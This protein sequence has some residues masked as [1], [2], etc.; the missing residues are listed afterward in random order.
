MET[1]Y[2]ITSFAIIP[3]LGF[4]VSLFLKEKN[5]NSLANVSF[6]S[7]LIQLVAIVGF[8]IYWTITGAKSMNIE[9]FVLYQSG[10]YKFL[11][12]FYFDKVTATYLL[13]GAFVTLLITR[14]SAYYMHLEAGYKRFFNTVLLFYFGYNLTVLA[15]NF[16]TLFIGWEILGLTSFLLIAFYRDRY[17]P[18]RNAVK[19]FSIY[20]IGDVG[21]L[22]AMWASHHLW[23]ENVSFITL[24]NKALVD[25][26]LVGHSWVGMLIAL[27]ILVAAAAKSAQFPFSSWLPRA[28]E[29]PTPSSAIFYGSLSVHF[30]VFLLLR[31]YPFWENQYGARIL[32]GVIGIISAVIGFM[33]TRVQSTIKTQ[34]AYASIAQI[35]LMFVEISLGWTTIALIHA[36]GNAML[37]TY[38]LLVSPSIVSYAIRDQFYHAKP[39]K[40]KKYFLRLTN[41]E[42]TLYVM[43]IKEWGLDSLMN[44]WIFRP[45]KKIGKSM[46]FMGMKF[47]LFVLI[48]VFVLSSYLLT[49]KEIIPFEIEHLLPYVYAIVAFLLVLKAFAERTNPML[50]WLLVYF[51][52]LWIALAISFN[53]AFNWTHILIYLSGTSLA[54]IVGFF[55]LNILK[56]KEKENFSLHHY[57]GHV[58]EY[59][60]LGL[61]FLLAT[62]G[63]MGF[64]ITMSFVGEDLIYSHIHS[65][66]IVL[67]VFYGQTYIMGGIALV[68]MYS[69]LFMGP[70]IKSYHEKS[71][72]SF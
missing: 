69:R 10:D 1:N 31:T 38:Q 40:V 52:N 20:R 50:A 64:P 17:L 49:K 23:H 25:E 37:R 24:Q 34:V 59:K 18:V 15:G 3:L 9:E 54:V 8:I 44:K 32:I 61:V 14:Y 45:M 60:N 70:H 72:K 58:F 55:C 41:L 26:H 13:I 65:D 4:I 53:E 28:M 47:T 46:K 29:G 16:E 30:G 71:L 62:M 33:I 39:K 7:V 48:P 27:S 68:R 6:Y 66:Q 63:L 51:S 57:Y 36:S 11:I 12:D 35:G 5:E 21:I 42:N 67:A 43:S 22:I 19:V 56:R 2:V